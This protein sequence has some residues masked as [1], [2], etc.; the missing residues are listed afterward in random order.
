MTNSTTSQSA[1]SSR[2]CLLV[3]GERL[4]VHRGYQAVTTRDLAQ[5]AGVNLGMIQYHFGSKANL[6]LDVVRRLMKDCG[7][8]VAARELESLPPSAAAAELALSRF[9]RVFLEQLL[10]GGPEGCHV[11]YREATNE[12]N[13]AELRREIISVAVS[14]FTAPVLAKLVQTLARIRPDVPA[15]A[16]E[17]VAHGILGQCTYYLS[18]RP[19]LES[20][21]QSD[22]STPAVRDRISEPLIA[23]ALGGLKSIPAPA[24]LPEGESA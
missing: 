17:P 21:W 24:E 16:L 18:N 15:A 23:L 13:P 8:A 9:V 1:R 6:F 7:G 19:F 10:G 3:A 4:F 20:A 12:G 5:A 11:M 22:L 2:E 14:E